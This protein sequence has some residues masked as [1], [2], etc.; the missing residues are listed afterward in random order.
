MDGLSSAQ[1]RSLI[2]EPLRGPFVQVRLLDFKGDA[3][4]GFFD[5]MDGIEKQRWKTIWSPGSQKAG[6]RSDQ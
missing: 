2:D 5:G 3:P 4:Q 1:H 6:T